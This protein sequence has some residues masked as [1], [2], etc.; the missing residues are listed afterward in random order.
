MLTFEIDHLDLLS[1]F[2]IEWRQTSKLINFSRFLVRSDY[3]IQ[4]KIGKW[5]ILLKSVPFIKKTIVNQ[6]YIWIWW[7]W[8]NFTVLQW[9]K[10]NYKISQFSKFSA[11]VWGCDLGENLIMTK[12]S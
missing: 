9:M 1:Q 6:V 11:K 4:V 8:L 5:L 7:F 3:A 12:T 10:K 2:Y